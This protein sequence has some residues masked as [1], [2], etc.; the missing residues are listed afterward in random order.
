MQARGE[1]FRPLVIGI[2]WSSSWNAVSTSAVGHA[3]GHIGSILNKAT[4]SD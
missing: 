3:T 2:T 4:D 1:A